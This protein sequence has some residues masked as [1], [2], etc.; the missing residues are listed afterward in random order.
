MNSRWV[1]GESSQFGA[2]CPIADHCKTKADPGL[3]W[4]RDRRPGSKVMGTS[5]GSIATQGALCS[6]AGD[7]LSIGT[8]LPTTG[9]PSTGPQAAW[10]WFDSSCHTR[11]KGLMQSLL[12]L[13]CRIQWTL[14]LWKETMID[15]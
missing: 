13:R 9:S 11:G 12:A 1:P 6:Q 14:S 10:H 2:C 3:P 7:V 4:C 8:V 5:K 15:P